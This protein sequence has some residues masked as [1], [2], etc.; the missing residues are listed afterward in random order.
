MKKLIACMIA[1]VAMCFA[2][3]GCGDDGADKAQKPKVYYSV[4]FMQDGTEVK[5]ISVESGKS[6]VESEIP[7]PNPKTG[8]IITWEDVDLS[9]VTTDLTINAVETPESYKITLSYPEDFPS[10]LATVTEIDVDYKGTF[11]L[12]SVK[13]DIVKGGWEI[14]SWQTQDGAQFPAT[15]VYELTEGITLKA[16]CAYISGLN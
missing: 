5:T 12:P 11:T 6:V 16:V 14:V 4:V 8:Y 1:V 15:G 3:V 2:F 9:K 10:E 7:T 13:A